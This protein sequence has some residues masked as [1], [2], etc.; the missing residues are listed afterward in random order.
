VLDRVLRGLAAG[1]LVW[2]SFATAAAQL[3][4]VETPE[5]RLLYVDPFETY[6]VPHVGS[7][8]INSL[9]FEHGL[10]GY[11]PTQK[12]T[13]LLTDFSDSGNAGATAVPR[14]FS[15][16]RSRRSRRPTK[17]SRQTSGSTGS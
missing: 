17:R 1:V 11:T 4:S 9:N 5:L 3:S 16:S 14:I 10:L 7:C 15:G 6:L 12:F 2:L 8:F 13:V